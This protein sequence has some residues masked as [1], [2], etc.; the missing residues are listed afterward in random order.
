M[1]HGNGCSW[2]QSQSSLA[3]PRLRDPHLA[4]DTHS[5]DGP[6][7]LSRSL[8][9]AGKS[10]GD[11]LSAEARAD[12]Y[13]RRLKKY[14]LPTLHLP[15]ESTM[16]RTYWAVFLLLLGPALVA[17][18]ADGTG[19]S[20]PLPLRVEVTSGTRPSVAAAGVVPVA[21]RVQDSGGHAVPDRVVQLQPSH[22]SVLPAQGHTDARGEFHSSWTVGSSTGEHTLRILIGKDVSAS[23]TALVVPGAAEVLRLS[24]KDVSLTA[25]RETVR[26][27]ARTEDRFGNVVQNVT[28]GWHSLDPAVATVAANGQITA[29]SGGTTRI[30]ADLSNSGDTRHLAD[31]VS[32]KVER[33]GAI[34]LTFDDGWKSTYTRAFPLLT[35]YGLKANVAVVTASTTWSGFLS[36]DELRALHEAGWSIVSH[37]VSHSRLTELTAGELERELEESKAWIKAQGFRGSSVFIVPYHAWGERE[38][39]AVRRHY[40][41][42]RGYTV[43]QFGSDSIVEWRPADPHQITGYEA[44]FAPLTT[45]EGR[46]RIQAYL[47]R[48]T[49][50]GRLLDIYFHDISDEMLEGF[51]ELVKILAQYKDSIHPYHQLF[52]DSVPP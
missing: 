49:S 46:R 14:I 17:C 23:I 10:P 13:S 1:Q 25:V 37:T 11:L 18:A 22:G 45:P 20:A 5:L 15:A 3:H 40:Q 29:H 21:I 35:Q 19:V 41:A 2:Q 8:K 43:N 48:A 24:Q 38:I 51:E 7:R 26:I 9:D 16:L 6:A 36:I 42:A 47:E 33:R 44:E 52:P 12:L 34:T 39:G 27:T 31:T 50:E 28:P 30:I 4:V 32:V